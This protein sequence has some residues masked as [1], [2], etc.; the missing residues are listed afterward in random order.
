MLKAFM[1][2]Y[3]GSGAPAP[4]I[5]LGRILGYMTKTAVQTVVV[6]GVLRWMGVL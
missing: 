6:V 4:H 3:R 5:A 2:G 1:E